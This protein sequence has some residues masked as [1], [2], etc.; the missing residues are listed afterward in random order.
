MYPD[1][2]FGFIMIS[3]YI[4]SRNTPLPPTAEHH[5]CIPGVLTPHLPCPSESTWQSLCH[6][7][8]MPPPN[9]PTSTLPSPETTLGKEIDFPL[10]PQSSPMVYPLQTNSQQ[11]CNI[12][13]S[14]WKS[15]LLVPTT[16]DDEFYRDMNED[17]E[18]YRDMNE[19][20]E[21]YRDM[22]EDEFYRDMNED[23]EFYRDMNEDEFYRD[24]N[25]DEFYR[26]MN[27][28]DEF[29]RDMNEDD[30]FYR[31]MNEDEFYR[32]MN[33]DDEFYRDMNEVYFKTVFFLHLS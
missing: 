31:D 32:D 29:Y 14:Q 23:D 8:E 17:D 20:D 9:P 16:V 3:Y 2:R 30:E 13:T 5:Q 12:S 28:D 15:L 18:F 19:D 4:I 25:E 7:P 10:L 33:E 21:F 24:M 1:I 22:N 26:D 27:E 6:R 11:S